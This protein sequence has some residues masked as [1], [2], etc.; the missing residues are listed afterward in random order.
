[1]LT[2]GR[3]GVVRFLLCLSWKVSSGAAGGEAAGVVRERGLRTVN[4]D[5]SNVGVLL[6]DAD[7]VRQAAVLE[8][9]A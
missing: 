6:A 4:A 5:M 2:T 9:V 1:M 7:P 8:R 3:D